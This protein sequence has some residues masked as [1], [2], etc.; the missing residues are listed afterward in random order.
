MLLPS[1]ARL[2]LLILSGSGKDESLPSTVAKDLGLHGIDKSRVST[3][4]ITFL[5]DKDTKELD[6][7]FSD[8]HLRE[9]LEWLAS[10]SPPQVAVTKTTTRELVLS[11]LNSTLQ[12]TGLVLTTAF[13]PLMKLWVDPWR[14]WLL[15]PMQIPQVGLVPEIDLLQESSDEYR[16]TAWYL[17]SVGWSAASKTEVLM[18]AMSN[19]KLPTLEDDLSWLA[20]EASQMMGV[21]LAQKEAQYNASKVYSLQ[22]QNMTYYIMPNWVSISKDIQLAVNEFKYW[23][24]LLK[25]GYHI[26]EF[27][28]N[29]TEYEAFQLYSPMAPDDADV[30][31]LMAMSS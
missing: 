27:R 15:Q 18:S 28:P 5:K 14:K 3:F 10:E 23:G 21:T 20:G 22:L 19:S 9:G 2:P 7:F 4:Y 17:P 24:S 30:A 6:G 11:H 29:F 26:Q 25:L 8:E 1:G 12:I 16:A 31:N 13:Q